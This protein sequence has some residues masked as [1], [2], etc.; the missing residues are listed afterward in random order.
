MPAQFVEPAHL[1]VTLRVNGETMQDESTEDMIFDVE[2]LR[3]Y[4]AERLRL[5]PGDLLLAASPAATAS[6]G[7]A[8]CRREDVIEAHAYR[9]GCSA[10]RAGRAVKVRRASKSRR[11]RARVAL[12]EGDELQLL[13]DGLPT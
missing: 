12:V 2:R 6:T 9:L 3:A 7:T 4:V 13:D 1:Q 10:T 5:F 8:S 11:R